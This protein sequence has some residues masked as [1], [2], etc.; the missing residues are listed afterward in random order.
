MLILVEVCK[1]FMLCSTYRIGYRHRGRLQKEMKEREVS[2]LGVAEENLLRALA[3]Y[4]IGI[5]L[6]SAFG[7]VLLAMVIC[8]H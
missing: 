5:S 7:D 2:E 6:V 8:R 4:D 1:L 3:A